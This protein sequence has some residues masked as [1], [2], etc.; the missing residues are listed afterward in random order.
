MDNNKNLKE[1]E[2]PSDNDESL[3]DLLDSLNDSFKSIQDHPTKTETL[4]S[5]FEIMVRGISD[6]KAL[7]MLFSPKTD[8]IINALFGQIE[9]GN[10]DKILMNKDSITK[11]TDMMFGEGSFRGPVSTS[12]LNNIQSSVQSLKYQTMKSH[13]GKTVAQMKKMNLIMKN[14]QHN[15]KNFKDNAAEYKK[16]EDAVYAIKQVMKFAAR[17][18]RNR[19]IIN[20]KVF[21]GL[22]N[23]VHEEYYED[24]EII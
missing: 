11:L 12:V 7:D 15:K 19:K 2:L 23:I 17:I 10:F 22:N 9:A 1:N 20:K 24:E 8:G 14:L 5:N 13:L 6:S 4:P 21:D 3:K 16:Y 18:Y